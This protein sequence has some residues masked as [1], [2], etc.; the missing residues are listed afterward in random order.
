MPNITF[1]NPV[2]QPT[3]NRRLINDLK[4]DLQ[5]G[6]FD[7]FKL[8]VAFAKVGPLLRME[9]LIKQWINSGKTVEAIIGIDHLGTS[10][11]AL[12]F[13]LNNFTNTYITNA[14][15]S[16]FHP[17]LYL[18]YGTDKANCYYGSHNLTVGGTETNFEGGLKV[19]FDLPT[20]Q[21]SFNEAISCW[22]SIQQIPATVQLTQTLLSQL[23]NEGRLHDELTAIRRQRGATNQNSPA[24]TMLTPALFGDFNTRPPSPLPRITPPPTQTPVQTVN[25]QANIPTA[26][27]VESLLI[28]IVP[29][30]NGEVFLSKTAV[31]QNPEFFGFPFNGRTIPKKAQNRSYPQRIPDPIV[32]FYVYDTTGHQVVSRMN[33]DLNMVFYE[34]KSEIRIQFPTDVLAHSGDFSIMVMTPSLNNPTY[35]YD[36]QIYQPGSQRYN[37]LLASCNQTL[38]SGGAAQSRKMGWL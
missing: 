36:I 35:D 9:Q 15:S 24:G 34:L 20:D 2:D 6:D 21:A 10:F 22:T 26:T 3:G 23:H 32:N 13:A 31:N 37:D 28:Q 17:K 12:E 33:H 27:P 4:S 11:Q 30:H 25:P 29:H 1:L 38:P 7:H 18:F 8:A 14:K 16:T 19:E 5:S